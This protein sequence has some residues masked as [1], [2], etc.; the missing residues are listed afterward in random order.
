MGLSSRRRRSGVARRCNGRKVVVCCCSEEVPFAFFDRRYV[1]VPRMRQPLDI[2]TMYPRFTNMA[3]TQ[4]FGTSLPLITKKA[5]ESWQYAPFPHSS[6]GNFFLFQ[7]GN[8]LDLRTNNQK[9]WDEVVV[10][11]QAGGCC[12][13]CKLPKPRM[14]VVLEL[15]RN[16]ASPDYKSRGGDNMIH[17][18]VRLRHMEMLVELVGKARNISQVSTPFGSSPL[19]FAIENGLKEYY[20][21]LCKMQA[22][23]SAIDGNGETVLTMC[24]LNRDYFE[25]L[26]TVI[27]IV[28]KNRDMLRGLNDEGLSV[29]HVAIRERQYHMLDWMT[30]QQR[31]PV[32]VVDSEGRPA[33]FYAVEQDCN[34]ACEILLKNG[35]NL[36]ARG[37]HRMT[38]L[39]QASILRR[40]EPLKTI[41]WDI[42]KSRSLARLNDYDRDGNT[43]KLEHLILDR[44]NAL[45]VSCNC[46]F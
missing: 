1:S 23:P 27:Q 8:C 18:A 44:L 17:R 21:Y 9:L 40:T 2:L 5:G 31:V 22:N 45:T 25:A 26:R 6:H 20:V 24:V 43:S 37:P 29:L 32:D 15:L 35:A 30:K 38:S 11:G 33:L 28:G 7:M 4:F 16:G 14:E 13:F 19:H 36:G 3:R 41:L 10:D 34:P 46:F 42:K 12:C 39:I